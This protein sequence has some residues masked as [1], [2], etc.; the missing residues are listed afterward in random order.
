MNEQMPEGTLMAE[1]A[2]GR[3][4]ALLRGGQLGAGQFV[5][6]RDSSS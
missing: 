4:I 6:I 2:Y 1:Q 5:S 3:L